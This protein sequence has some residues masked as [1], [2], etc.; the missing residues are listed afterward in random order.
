VPTPVAAPPPHRKEKQ[1][2]T[3]F[4]DVGG[5]G[6]FVIAPRVTARA[7]LPLPPLRAGGDPMELD[8]LYV[9]GPPAVVTAAVD[10]LG[11]YLAEVTPGIVSFFQQHAGEPTSAPRE[12]E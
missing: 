7:V 12:G 11:D 10:R 9:S 5:D 8:L 6:E 1:V 2:T 4:V 3:Q